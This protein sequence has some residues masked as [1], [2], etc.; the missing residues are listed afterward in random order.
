[1]DSLASVMWSVVF[2]SVG[3]GFFVYG[4][5]QRSPMPYAVGA[6]LV[7]LPYFAPDI[8][9]LVGLGVVLTALP[10]WLK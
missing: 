8:Y 1:M 7:A 10:F 2:G 5:R 6:A 4:K 9:W 3:V